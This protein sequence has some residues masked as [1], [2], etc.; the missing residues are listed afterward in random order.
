MKFGNLLNLR[1]SDASHAGIFAERR[2]RFEKIR[3]CRKWI[4]QKKR[5]LEGSR[6]I[7][8]Q[9]G[10]KDVKSKSAVCMY[11]QCLEI[12]LKRIEDYKE[13]ISNKYMMRIRA[14]RLLI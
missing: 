4:K 8:N 10:A 13:E 2:L 9:K 1:P 12:L 5:M 11:G 7:F 14:G 3:I 6:Y